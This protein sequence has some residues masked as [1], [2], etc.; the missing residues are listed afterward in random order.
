MKCTRSTVVQIAFA[1]IYVILCIHRCGL[2]RGQLC[3]YR[4]VLYLL[5]FSPFGAFI[6]YRLCF[7]QSVA[8]EFYIEFVT[9]PH[10]VH[11]T[12]AHVFVY[13]GKNDQTEIFEFNVHFSNFQFLCSYVA[14]W[15]Y[16]VY[17]NCCL[18]VAYDFFLKNFN[19]IDLI[20]EFSTVLHVSF[21]MLHL[22]EYSFEIYRFM[23]SCF[24][25]NVFSFITNYTNVTLIL[26]FLYILLATNVFDVMFD[27]MLSI[28]FVF[29]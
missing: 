9:E 13:V 4:I 20:L 18:F 23:T 7:Y 10:I 26:I 11:R 24:P 25:S 17:L 15:I 3:M 8:Y 12:R 21:H 29:F 1:C 6:W 16:N 14:N 27:R 2:R 28:F 22:P 19:V 5:F